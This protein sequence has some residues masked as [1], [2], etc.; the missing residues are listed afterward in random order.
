MDM[1][2]GISKS[3]DILLSSIAGKLDESTKKAYVIDRLSDNLSNNLSSV[4]DEN[5]CNLA[6][7]S[8]GENPVFLIDYSDIIKPLGDKTIVTLAD[9]EINSYLIKRVKEKYPSHCVDREEEQ[10]GKIDYVWVCD[11]VDG[12]AMYARHIPVAVFSLA[13]VIEGESRVGV[14]YDPFTDSLYTAIKGKGAFKNNEKINVNNFE[15]GD[16]RSV[17]NFEMWSVAP[18]NIYDIGKELGKK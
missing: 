13:L 15:L 11:Q 7:D 2:Y 9:T 12:T 8:L 10:F 18:Y 14:V 1:I 3:K 5:Y 4:I 17:S 6:M 16:I